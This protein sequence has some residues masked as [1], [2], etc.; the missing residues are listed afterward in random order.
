MGD[1][2]HLGDQKG[3]SCNTT[4]IACHWSKSTIFSYTYSVSDELLC[5]LGWACSSQQ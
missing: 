1:G 2:T 4:D 3:V 5:L